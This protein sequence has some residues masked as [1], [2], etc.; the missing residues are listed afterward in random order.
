MRI[1]CILCI[2]M[3]YKTVTFS[4]KLLRLDTGCRIL[5]MLVGIFLFALV[6]LWDDN[7]QCVKVSASAL[8]PSHLIY[9]ANIVSLSAA[10]KQ[11]SQDDFKKL[12][13]GASW[14][15]KMFLKVCLC[16]C[17]GPFSSDVPHQAVLSSVAPELYCS[18]RQPLQSEQKKGKG[19]SSLKPIF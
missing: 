16:R 14:K 17:W 9:K 19:G 18:L 4:F 1:L 2:L 7:K 13:K 15:W 10:E 8:S 6:F 11:N 3:T 5:L 12:S